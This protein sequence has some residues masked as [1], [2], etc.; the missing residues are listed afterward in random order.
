MKSQKRPFLRAKPSSPARRGVRREQE[1]KRS[2]ETAFTLFFKLHC[3]YFVSLSLSNVGEFC[4]LTAVYYWGSGMFFIVMVVNKVPLRSQT[5]VW[6][7]NPPRS[8]GFFITNSAS[9]NNWLVSGH[10]TDC[11]LPSYFSSIEKLLNW[12]Q[13]CAQSSQSLLSLFKCF[14]SD[15]PRENR[16]PVNSITILRYCII[17]GIFT[18]V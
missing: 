12:M 8:T 3:Y 11:T 14:P 1:A 18:A 9:S 4:S 17:S 5:K 10:S 6:G 2:P 7:K 15:M 13:T 16:E